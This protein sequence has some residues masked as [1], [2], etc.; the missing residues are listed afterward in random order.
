L[1]REEP[2]PLVE[3][4]GASYRR[5]EV[6]KHDSWAA[7]VLYR[8]SGP[9]VVC[10]FNR[11]QPIFGVP[12]GWL[13]NWLA[14][15]EARVL[16]RLQGLAHVP[17]LTGEVFVAGTRCRNAFAHDYVPG[18][19]LGRHEYVGDDFFPL[20]QRLLVQ[21]HERNVAYVDLTKRENIIVG[22]DGRPCII[23]FQI[24]ALLPARWPG[25][26]LPVRMFLKCLQRADRYHLEKHHARSRP[27]QTGFTSREIASRR[28][29]WIRAHRCVAVPVRASRRWLLAVLGIRSRG[30]RADSEYF[31]EDVVRQDAARERAK[32]S[33]EASR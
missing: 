8:G 26:S 28:P 19:P 7:T 13:G 32:R 22:E 6:L 11:R 9:G 33:G 29:W 2:P 21:M 20:L 3:I 12:M 30:G 14:R 24:S 17:R 18:H 10:K 23:D 25:N 4:G 1:G 16:R 15:H 31:P 27:D 5:I